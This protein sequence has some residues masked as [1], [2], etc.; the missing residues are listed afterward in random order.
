MLLLVTKM[1]LGCV[2][3]SDVL[4]LFEACY[5]RLECMLLYGAGN[6][7]TVVILLSNQGSMSGKYYG[8]L[9]GGEASWLGISGVFV[10]YC[11]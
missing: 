9:V 5:V 7:L 3:Q 10:Y 2:G 6:I 8:V 1:H 11:Y 4:L